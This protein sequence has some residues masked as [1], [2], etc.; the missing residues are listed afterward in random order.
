MSSCAV[1]LPVISDSGMKL[2]TASQRGP[3]EAPVTP[4][5]AASGKRVMIA[6]LAPGVRPVRPSGERLKSYEELEELGRKTA[7]EIVSG[8]PG[9][10][11]VIESGVD[12]ATG[13]ASVLMSALPSKVQSL[14]AKRSYASD[15]LFVVDES[16]APASLSSRD[17]DPSPHSGGAKI[18]VP[19]GG[20]T[21]GFMWNTGRPDAIVFAGHCA[22]AGGWGSIGPDSIEIYSG[23]RENWDDGVGTVS[24]NGLAIGD[25]AMGYIRSGYL[26]NRGRIYVGGVSSN[27]LRTVG[28][29]WG[30]YPMAGDQY[31]TGGA[32]FGELCGYVVQAG[33]PVNAFYIDQAT[34]Q[35]TGEARRVWVGRKS[36]GACSGPGDS[37][38]P[39][40]TVA[41]DG[42]VWAKGYISGAN[43]SACRNY[44]TSQVDADTLLPGGV[45]VGA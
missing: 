31:C 43:R 40:Y 35:F 21:S 27:S 12:L 10:A 4:E 34:N 32:S 5:V 38:G 30:R 45:I 7:L 1:E 23:S 42:K 19:A 36:S 3:I 28:G 33:G 22:P 20:C 17:S 26:V 39:V 24:M 2:F 18:R 9:E 37:G 6:S 41:T 15:L 16:A 29:V 25:I 11:L 44:F 8:F 14:F 13:R